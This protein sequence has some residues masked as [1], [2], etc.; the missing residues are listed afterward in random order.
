M[1]TFNQTQWGDP[2]SAAG[3]LLVNNYSTVYAG[4]G[5]LLEVGIAGAGGFSMAFTT[6]AAVSS[7]LPS[8]GG[9]AALTSDLVD[10]TSSSSGVYGGEVVALKLNIDFSAAGALVGTSHLGDLRICGFAPLPL[11]NNMTVSQFL[12]IAN[13]LL[14]GGSASLSIA[15]ATS[16]AAIINSAFLDGS[17]S[18]FAQDNLVAGA[19]P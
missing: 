19:C 12:A 13:H 17:P 3:A 6:D 5:N 1:L 7:Y 8:A 10:P 15:Q 9:F 14:G 11:V 18:V 2:A 4:T 16:M